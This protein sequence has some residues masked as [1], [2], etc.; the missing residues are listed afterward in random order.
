MVSE[1]EQQVPTELTFDVAVIGGGLAGMAASIHLAKRGF[2]VVC[3]E[4]STEFG[5]MV[6][7]SLDWSAPE[8][9]AEIDLHMEELVG[10]EISTVKRHVSL[11]VKDG[12]KTEY[13]PSAWLARPPLNVELRTLHLDRARLH[14]NLI[15]LA[16]RYGVRILQD[17]VA[18]IE[19]AGRRI[20][21]LGTSGGRRIS[22]Q[23]FIDAAGGA[24]SLFG[25][26]F[27]L[28]A[29]QYGPP[30]VAIWNYFPASLSREGTTLYADAMPGRYMDWIWEIPINRTTISVGYV[31]AGASVKEKRQQSLSVEDIYRNQ[32]TKFERF[33][34]LTERPECEEPKVTSFSCRTF[35]EVCG[36]NWFII[37]EAASTPDP[38]T[39]NGVTAALRHA[40]EA[41][42]LIARFRDSG[43]ISWWART[44]Y[45]RRVLQ[46][47]RFFN[48]LIEKLAYE[49]PVRD[50]IGLLTTGDIYTAAAW[51]INHLYSRFQ[52]SGML[53]TAVWGSFLTSLRGAAWLFYRLCQWMQPGPSRLPDFALSNSM[54]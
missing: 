32:L 14:Q 45:N 31:T 6:G 2:E 46:M 47:G 1:P 26:E 42:K 24:A 12:G 40:A 15:R 49:C 4:P 48:S 19:R 13:V 33:R 34:D 44:A 16:A 29:L 28:R 7:E 27:R 41:S 17:R 43:R 38:V 22:A 20:S 52:P 39:G 3:I 36:P 9:F 18:A 23:W 5:R 35:R 50:R 21:A 51:S 10:D 53:A 37:G 30:K 54:A 25:R 11:E 8:L